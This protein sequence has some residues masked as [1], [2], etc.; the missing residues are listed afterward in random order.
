[1]SKPKQEITH[2]EILSIIKEMRVKWGSQKE[3]ADQLGISSA[4]LSDI[5]NEKQLVSDAVARKLGY[6]RIVKYVPED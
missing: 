4:Y 1:M 3:L 5:I 2:D 6:T